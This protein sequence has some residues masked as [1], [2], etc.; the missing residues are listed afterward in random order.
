MPSTKKKSPSASASRNAI[1]K[2]KAS[3]YN[4][5]VRTTTTTTATTTT[6][7]SGNN[8]K[9][10]PISLNKPSN[11]ARN[12]HHNTNLT[13]ELD[14]L[15]DDL[16]TQLQRKK[17]KRDTRLEDINSSGIS[18]SEKRLNEAQ[19]KHESLQQDMMSALDGISALGK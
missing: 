2:S 18:E 17:T 9:K 11:Q 14:A 1:G 15:L 4:K 3:P 8:Q 7:T 13:S 12:K 6:T 5:N 19:E 10:L 16:N